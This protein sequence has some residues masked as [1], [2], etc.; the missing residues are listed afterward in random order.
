MRH[1]RLRLCLSALLSC[2][3]L[4]AQATVFTFDAEPFLGSTALGTP[5]RQ[6]V[7]GEPGVSFVIS[8]DRFAFAPG[9]FPLVGPLQFASGEANNLPAGGSNVLVLQTLDHDADPATPFAAGTAANLIADRV[10]SPG[11]GFFVYF[12]SGLDLPRL[13]YSTDLSDN[14]ADLKILARLT[15]LGGPTG[16]SALSTFTADNF[17]SPVPELPTAWLLALPLAALLRLQ[18][19]RE[20]RF[21]ALRIQTDPRERGVAALDGRPDVR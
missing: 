19:L 16:S 18:R 1:L 8:S 9:A 4:S 21:S 20:H 13:V 6:I 14:T 10:T 3:G 17:T 12:N 5:G 2:L 11:A 15:N 7:G